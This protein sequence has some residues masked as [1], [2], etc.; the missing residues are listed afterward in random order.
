LETIFLLFLFGCLVGFIGGYAGIGGAPF[1]VACLVALFGFSQ[2]EAQGTVLAVMLGPMSLLSVISLWDKVKPNLLVISIGVVT[3][4]L[5]SYFG[6]S[7][8]Y[9]LP[10]RTLKIFFACLLIALG[11]F[12]IISGKKAGKKQVIDK[13]NE[14]LSVPQIAII[15]SIVGVVGGLFGIGAGVLMVPLFINVFRVNKDVARAISLAILLPPVSIGAVIKYNQEGAINWQYALV[16]F[17]SYFIVN[18]FGGK[19]G[20]K[21]DLKKFKTYFGLIMILLGFVYFYLIFR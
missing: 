15:G 14:S 8:A 16:L 18:Y 5:M 1:L 6:A 10:E 17:L 13:G 9:L 21:H 7:L 20:A 2:F 19:M 12:D 4:A 3:Y 11:L